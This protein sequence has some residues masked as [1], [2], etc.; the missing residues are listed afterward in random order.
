MP[1]QRSG[2][3]WPGMHDKLNGVEVP[4]AAASQAHTVRWQAPTPHVFETAGAP[5]S[6]TPSH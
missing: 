5:L 1:L 6:I 3:G 4:L 2:C